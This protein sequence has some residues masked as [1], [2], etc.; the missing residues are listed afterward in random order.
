[1]IPRHHSSQPTNEDSA[2]RL[3]STN[4][5][6]DDSS[7]Q[8]PQNIPLYNII[9]IEDVHADA[10]LIKYELKK[11]KIAFKART[12]ADRY[13][14]LKEL[15][16]ELPD[17][18]ISDF[19]MPQF[20]ALDALQLLQREG[21]DIPFI[22]VT[23]SQ[24]E[25]VAV[26][27]IKKG[28]DDYI[29]KSSLKRLPSALLSA[30]EKKNVEREREIAVEALRE[31]E[32]HFRSLI[33]ISSDIISI[34][35]ADGIIL[36]ESPAVTRLLGYGVGELI[37]NKF[38]SYVHPNDLSEF[39]QAFSLEVRNGGGNKPK[40][41]SYRFKHQDGSWRFLESLI[42]NQTE[43][44]AVR[45]LVITSR[46]ITE[47][48]VAEEQI[49]EQAALL[50]KAQD[51]I[52]A[53]DLNAWTFSFWNHSA[54]KLYGWTS[55]EV[56]GK[57][58]GDLI[59][60]N[61]A[62]KALEARQQTLKRGD[63][64]GEMS[65]VTKSGAEL[66]VESRWS[67]VLNRDGQPKSILI[68][69]TDITERKKLEA[70]FL[71][72]Q[73]MESIGTLAGGIAHEL[74]NVLTP[75][76][77]SIKMLRDH[78]TDTVELSILE[79]LETSAHRGASIVQQVL[80]FARGVESERTLIQIRHPLNEVIKIARETFPP[81]IQIKSKIGQDL[82]PVLGDATQLHQVFMN[83]LVNA[84]DA[85]P[86]GGRLQ[87]EAEN[88]VIDESYAKMQPDAQPGPYVVISVA[89][90]GSGMAPGLLSKIF[91]PFFTTKEIGKGTGLG[92]STA[93]GIV[94]SHKGFLTVYSEQGKGSC[95]KVHLPAAEAAWQP[96]AASEAKALPLGHGE[97]IL[98][99]DDEAAIRE[100]IKV[101]LEN[102]GYSV[103]T[104]SDGTEAV[105][106]FAA[107]RSEIDGIVVDVMMPY[108]DGPAT[109]RAIQKLD[110]SARFIAI[111]GLME[112]EKIA[113][114]SD[115]GQI[116]F[117]AKPFT[118]EQILQQLHNLLQKDAV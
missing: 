73:R 90:T 61:D 76:I 17:A 85:M 107:Q 44:P 38:V 86:Y 43:N 82:C 118:T 79:T 55:E 78:T 77:M 89:D 80:S 70:H 108:M 52:I 68:I 106:L 94:K 95:F 71:R 26:E 21:I 88:A 4:Y 12:V 56:I 110:P 7:T 40:A 20:N 13:G 45:G 101:T 11:N 48:K 30:I 29:L 63:W 9:L 58:S 8:P 39:V 83:L 92:L 113:E 96:P 5:D 114:M 46:D 3:G 75:F 31:S 18:I 27:C 112:N 98:V 41:F 1:M 36:Y 10:E 74:N 37:G 6:R 104:A 28:A 64:L 97:T 53:I 16:E 66:T 15:R 111:S 24:S 117:L 69:N 102:N 65:Q 35:S 100:I 57:Q 49:R 87:I 84:R 81:V 115:V 116:S 14:F 19:S 32:E 34:V 54:E 72:A 59:S 47:R 62:S 25:E 42:K 109:I 103:I 33:D 99:V 2:E 51:A 105:A 50:N 93:L 67:L 60:S 91:E 23:G 22:L